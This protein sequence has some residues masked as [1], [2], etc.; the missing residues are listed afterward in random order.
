VF[1]KRYIVMAAVALLLS[2]GGLI[3]TLQASRTAQVGDLAE[4]HGE[5]IVFED[6]ASVYCKLFRRDIAP[7]YIASRS[8]RHVPMRF[9][10]AIAAPALPEGLVAPITTVPTVVF[11]RDGREEGRIAGYVGPKNFSVMVAKL[12][13]PVD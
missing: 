7:G 4:Q 8:A 1:F 10:D 12:I 5:L 6:P 2:A 3:S 13:G 9:V 11:M